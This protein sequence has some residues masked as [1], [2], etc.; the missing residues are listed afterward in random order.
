MTF[1]L[2]PRVCTSQ[3]VEARLMS[4]VRYLHFHS[5][6]AKL[7]LG[8]FVMALIDALNLKFKDSAL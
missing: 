8:M 2:L 5:R 3:L 1:A 4:S 7:L 6:D